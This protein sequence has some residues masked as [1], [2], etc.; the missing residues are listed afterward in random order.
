[1]ADSRRRYRSYLLR[2]WQAG[3]GAAPEWRI[4][5]EDVITHER[6]SFAELASMLAFLEEQIGGYVESDNRSLSSDAEEH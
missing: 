3:N 5:L 6:H 2:V 4:S 1:M